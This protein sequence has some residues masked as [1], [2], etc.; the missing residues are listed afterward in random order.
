MKFTTALV[1]GRTA[2]WATYPCIFVTTSG[3][4]VVNH[5]TA[6]GMIK[7][8]ENESTKSIENKISS[9]PNYT[10]S[11]SGIWSVDDKSGVLTMTVSGFTTAASS[12]TKESEYC[13]WLV[14]TTAKTGYGSLTQQMQPRSLLLTSF[15]NVSSKF[16]GCI[17]WV[18][19]P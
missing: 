6:Y 10:L 13:E 19:E 9:S 5:E 8:N 1:S 18:R 7:F 12:L 16:L 3:E 15:R 14:S 4:V 11:I 2:Y 17:C